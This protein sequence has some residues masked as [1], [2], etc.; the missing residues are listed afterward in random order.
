[1]LLHVFRLLGDHLQ[2]RCAAPSAACCC[3]VRSWPRELNASWV[4]SFNRVVLPA[5]FGPATTCNGLCNETS[6]LPSPRNRSTS[7]LET[8]TTQTRLSFLFQS[9]KDFL[10]RAG[11]L[12]ASRCGPR[13][14]RLRNR[15]VEVVAETIW[16]NDEEHLLPLTVPLID[17]PVRSLHPLRFKLVPHGANVRHL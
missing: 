6:S 5:L 3:S 16:G 9:L 10:V 12:G 11:D 17:P 8:S 2:R 1:M 4:S 14:G 15:F 7:T 13:P